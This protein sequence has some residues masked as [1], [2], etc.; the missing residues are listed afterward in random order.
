MLFHVIND[1]DEH[2]SLILTTNVDLSRWGT[3][4]SD[5]TIAAAILDGLIHHGRILRFTGKSWRLSHALM[6]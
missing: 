5:D 2:H 3:I 4:F 1:T 6:A